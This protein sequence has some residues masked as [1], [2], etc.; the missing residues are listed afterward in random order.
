[1]AHNCK[2]GESHP[3]C[4]DM[5]LMFPNLDYYTHGKKLDPNDKWGVESFSCGW[6]WWRT[7]KPR[8]TMFAMKRTAF[9]SNAPSAGTRA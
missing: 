9:E 3:V 5:P 4:D 2:V 7:M 8:C 6:T 1:M